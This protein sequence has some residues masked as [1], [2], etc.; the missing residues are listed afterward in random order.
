MNGFG[1]VNIRKLRRER[2]LVIKINRQGRERGVGKRGLR[3]MFKEERE[4]DK[5]QK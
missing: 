3:K 1:K 2:E 4:R 5:K